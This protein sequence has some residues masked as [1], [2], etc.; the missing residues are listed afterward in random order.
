MFAE[1]IEESGGFGLT[2]AW[3]QHED[4]EAC[5]SIE[6]IIGHTQEGEEIADVGGFEESEAAVFDEGDIAASEFG[7]EGHA[8][9]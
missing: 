7:F 2:D 1:L 3:E 6:R 9:V 8:V 4:A 5:D